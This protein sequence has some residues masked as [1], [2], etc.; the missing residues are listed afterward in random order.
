MAP[1]PSTRNEPPRMRE[2]WE[3]PPDPAE[4]S[5]TPLEP[6]ASPD[7]RPGEPPQEPH[8]ALT[9]PAHDPDLTLES[10]PYEG[11]DPDVELDELDAED[12]DA[13]WGEDELDPDADPGDL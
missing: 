2:H 7:P 4:A 12:E 3:R 6:K 8:H 5:S 9:R 11:G 1:R 13:D 10:D